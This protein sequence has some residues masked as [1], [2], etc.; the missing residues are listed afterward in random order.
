MHVFM[1]FLALVLLSIGCSSGNTSRDV[2][3]DGQKGTMTYVIP[4]STSRI[5]TSDERFQSYNVEM[6]EVTGGKFWK[7]Y[8]VET[9][10]GRSSG[11]AEAAMT[12]ATEAHRMER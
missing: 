12:S 8:A 2:Q 5:G 9:A 4:A 1:L 11:W 3:R 6:L 10:Y 7:P